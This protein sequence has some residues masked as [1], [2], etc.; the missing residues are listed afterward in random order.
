M[1]PFEQ[2]LVLKRRMNSR[3]FHCYYITDRKGLAPRPLLP[4]LQAG[5][6]A[7]VDL[8]QLREKD[9][10]TP[11][12]VN[13]AK[14]AIESSRGSGTR[15]LI[16]DRLDIAVGVGA[17]G[18]HLG[19]QSLP[20]EVVRQEIGPHL[21]MGVSCHSIEEALQA[22]IAGADYV[23][24]GPIFETPSKRPYGPPLGLARLSEA[25]RRVGVPVIALGGITLGKVAACLTAGASGIAGIRLFQDSSSLGDR[26]QELRTEFSRAQSGTQAQS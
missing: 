12:L 18:I 3:P 2:N 10:P 25:A 26:V 4:R 15:I 9:L 11:E 16:N 17:D 19:R 6:R 8:I 14:A 23:L 24:F 22:E 13:L 7:G 21:L 1:R 5:I 20:P